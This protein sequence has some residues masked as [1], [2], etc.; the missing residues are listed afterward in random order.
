[1]E[2]IDPE[3]RL[4]ARRTSL[5]MGALLAQT[6][7]E[8]Q[9]GEVDWVMEFGNRQGSSLRGPNERGLP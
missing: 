3:M 1:M 8:E 6:L 9:L 5:R 7:K 2:A 4:A